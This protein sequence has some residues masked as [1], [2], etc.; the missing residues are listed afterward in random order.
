MKFENIIA[1]GWCAAA[2]L[3]LSVNASAHEHHHHDDKGPNGGRILH[4][5]DPHLE[6]LVLANRKVQLTQLDGKLKAT[7]MGAQ[8]VEMEAGSPADR[9]TIAFEKK[10]DVLVSKQPLPKGDDVPVAVM[11][12]PEPG[13]DVITEKFTVEIPAND[14]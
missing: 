10:G 1:T 12:R 8:E 7:S 11:I 13:A 9:V 5:V 4:H 3:L 6:F 2:L 14:E